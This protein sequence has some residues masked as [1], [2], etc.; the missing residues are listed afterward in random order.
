MLEFWSGMAKKIDE[1]VEN[2]D[3]DYYERQVF[4]HPYAGRLNL[5]Q[6]LEFLANH[7]HHHQHQLRRMGF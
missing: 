6:T 7:Y 1:F 2:L 3:E 4:K 5:Y